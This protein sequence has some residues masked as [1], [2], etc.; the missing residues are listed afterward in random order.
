MIV[1]RTLKTQPVV[2]ALTANAMEG[3]EEEYLN[4]GMDDYTAS[5]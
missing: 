2:I 4:A 1:R 3:N 5:R